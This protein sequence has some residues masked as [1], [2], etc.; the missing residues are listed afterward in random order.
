[1]STKMLNIYSGEHM[2]VA[3]LNCLRPPGPNLRRIWFYPIISLVSIYA[4]FRVLSYYFACWLSKGDL[5]PID[6]GY[7]GDQEKEVPNSLVELERRA[8]ASLPML[9]VHPILPMD[10]PP[11]VRNSENYIPVYVC[12]WPVR[13]EW[14]IENFLE[15]PHPGGDYK[16]LAGLYARIGRNGGKFMKS[17]VLDEEGILCV[18]IV[19]AT[20]ETQATM[21]AMKNL[22]NVRRVNEAMG[23]EKEPMW[24]AV[25]PL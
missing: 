22:E 7:M 5:G 4:V 23:M 8:E 1:M 19:I 24:Y 25:T 15:S 13:W 16:A 21:H 12:G 17:H 18:C 10:Q 14:I 6:G 3:S 9:K 11:A 2:T 20:N